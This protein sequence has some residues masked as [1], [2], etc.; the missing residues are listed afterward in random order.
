MPNAPR[1]SAED[2]GEALFALLPTGQE[3]PRD[4]DED[5]AKFVHGLASVF[6]EPFDTI[7][8]RFLDQESDPRFTRDLLE[9]WETAF[10]LPDS[11]L[12]EP[13]TI[14]ARIAALMQRMTMEGGQSRAFFYRVAAALGYTIE[15]YE[16]SPFMAGVSEAGDT[17]DARGWY[18]WE[19]G[20]P[21]MRFYWK[22]A[23]LNARL[24]WFRAGSGEAG[25]DHHLEIGIAS[26]LECVLRRYKPAHTEIV[27]DYSGLAGDDPFAG[28][29]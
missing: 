16:F 18:R 5:L 17:R 9:R 12:S 13:V 23:V 15:I 14:E 24:S 8:A 6:G 25:V 3:W 1:H 20:A 19:V 10:G 29:P 28:T 27:F 22:V 2:Y 7:A 11:C 21:E 26:D 4:A